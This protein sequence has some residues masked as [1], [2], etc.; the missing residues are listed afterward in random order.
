M[1]MP[2]MQEMI[3]Y[4]IDFLIQYLLCLIKL[5]RCKPFVSTGSLYLCTNT[6]Y[7]DLKESHWVSEH[8]CQDALLS[9]N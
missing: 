7:Y 3:I 9:R 8:F 6:V 4:S 5:H 1:N 2:S